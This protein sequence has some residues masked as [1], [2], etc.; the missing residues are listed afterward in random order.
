[1][2][3]LSTNIQTDTRFITRFWGFIVRNESVRFCIE[4]DVPLWAL[5]KSS[6]PKQRSSV[7][8]VLS[9][10]LCWKVCAARGQHLEGAR[11]RYL[12]YLVFCETGASRPC[13]K[14][15]ARRNFSTSQIDGV[16]GYNCIDNIFCLETGKLCRL[17]TSIK[18]C[19]FGVLFV[20]E[21]FIAHSFSI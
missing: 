16:S 6:Q 14:C 7:K 10:D 12:Y 13:D 18:E 1:M 5:W 17:I 15:K 8:A 21:I 4:S 2:L 19:V 9:K 11:H 20:Y 3:H